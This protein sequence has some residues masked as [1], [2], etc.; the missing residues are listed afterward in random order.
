MD[1]IDMITQRTDADI[2]CI[3]QA[4]SEMP[5]TYSVEERLTAGLE[6]FPA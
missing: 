1:V 2:L 3:I 5:D 6:H 4:A